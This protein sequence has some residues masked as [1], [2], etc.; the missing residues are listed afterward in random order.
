MESG[1]GREVY[2]HQNSVAGQ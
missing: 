2:F 1:E